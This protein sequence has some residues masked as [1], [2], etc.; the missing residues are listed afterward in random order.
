MYDKIKTCE[1]VNLIKI[2]G[3][4]ATLKQV[5]LTVSGGRKYKCP[6]CNGKGKITVKYNAY[7]KGLPDSG[8]VY[9]EAFKDIECDIC[10]GDGYTREEY[11]PKYIQDGFEVVKDN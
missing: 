8:F 2:F 5:L 11:R 1:I 4:D 7:P 3:E 9:E 10:K 6:K